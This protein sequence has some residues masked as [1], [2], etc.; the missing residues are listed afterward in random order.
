MGVHNPSVK[1]LERLVERL[2]DIVAM[3]YDIVYDSRRLNRYIVDDVKS[4]RT[5]SYTILV[6]ALTHRQRCETTSYDIVDDCQRSPDDI[7]R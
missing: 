6:G 3:S 2:D 4:Y 7:V 5:I 1:S